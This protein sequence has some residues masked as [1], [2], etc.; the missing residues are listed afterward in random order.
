MAHLVFFVLLF[1]GQL[2]GGFSTQRLPPPNNGNIITVLSIDGGGIRGILPATVLDYLD[3]ALKARNPNADLAHYFDVIGGTS[4]GGLITAMLATPSPHDPSRAVFTPA[5]I[6]DFYKQNGP[7]IFNESRPGKGSLFDGE[8]LHNITRE[9]LKDTRLNQTLTNVVIPTFDIKTQ[10]PVIFSNYKLENAPYLNAL[11]SDISISTSAAPTQLPPYYFVNDG[12]E[13]NMVDGGFA[14]GNPTQPTISEVL[15]HNEYPNILVLSVGTGTEK[16]KE[17]FDA[18]TAANWKPLEWISPA[19]GFLGRAPTPWT[20]YYLESL[21]VG[22]Q[23]GDI[24]LRIEEYDLNPDFSNQVNASQESMN[25]L[26]ETG[27]QLLQENV[28]KLN[29]DTFDLEKLQLKNSEGLDR[30]ADILLGERQRRL[31]RKSIEKRGRPLLESLRVFSDKAQ[32]TSALLRNL[33]I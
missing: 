17:T 3:K 10:K 30:I 24:Y 19:I 7:H 14:A 9:L 4:T 8:F 2:I 1:A 22:S 31:K 20:E 16:I 26:E 18:Q 12:V 32:A 28:V 23:P 25:G 6:V 13:F 33:F 15:Q 27:K 5:Q 21:F 11:L 29:L